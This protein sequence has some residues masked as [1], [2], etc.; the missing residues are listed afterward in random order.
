MLRS[1][2]AAIRAIDPH[3]MEPH[4]RFAPISTLVIANAYL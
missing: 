1:L 4:L 3:E 2:N